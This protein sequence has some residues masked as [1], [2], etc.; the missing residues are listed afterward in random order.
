MVGPAEVAKDVKL[1]ELSEDTEVLGRLEL[2]RSVLDRL[3]LGRVVL[4]RLVLKPEVLRLR[5]DIEVPD[6]LVLKAEVLRFGEDI[7][8]LGEAVEI[9]IPLKEPREDTETLGTPTLWEG[10]ESEVPLSVL[11]EGVEM[12][13]GGEVMD[14]PVKLE[15]DT[16]D[17]E[18]VLE[19]EVQLKFNEDTEKLNDGV[20]MDDPLRPVKDT[21]TLGGL[22][23]PEM[24]GLDEMPGRVKIVAVS[25]DVTVT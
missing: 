17:L 10:V 12:L 8:T 24:V 14:V 4:D 13:G 15:G 23:W 16:A 1:R 18:D 6:R 5:E 21:D 9:D 2:G 19:T 20:A 25:V 7:E 11:N 3:V 22:V